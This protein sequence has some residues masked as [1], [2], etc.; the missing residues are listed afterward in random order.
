LEINSRQKCPGPAKK[1]PAGG[2]FKLNSAKKLSI[3]QPWNKS[4]NNKK[5]FLL[6]SYIKYIYSV[7]KNYSLL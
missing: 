6:P 3:F 2:S 7:R 5:L 1:A 4:L